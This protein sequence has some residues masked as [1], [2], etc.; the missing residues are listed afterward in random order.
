MNES[1]L[2]GWGGGRR[3]REGPV[4]GAPVPPALSER[5]PVL[6]LPP[7]GLAVAVA[8]AARGN[9]KDGR[10]SPERR[11][12]DETAYVTSAAGYIPR[13]AP[14][15]L[16]HLRTCQARPDRNA[17]AGRR[18]L[19]RKRESASWRMN[20]TLVHSISSV[21]FPSSPLMIGAAVR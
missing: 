14:G 8:P 1:V 18:A 19:D 12:V 16:T 2:W 7:A 9:P 15:C 17:L 20:F 21:S 3:R 6:F 5:R 13:P 10:F 11:C 4:V